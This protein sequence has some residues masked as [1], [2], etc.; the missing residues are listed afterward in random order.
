MLQSALSHTL[1]P[2]LRGRAELCVERGKDIEE[3][4]EGLGVA[5]RELKDCAG[6]G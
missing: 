3:R 6:M 2:S 4:E 5:E 1:S